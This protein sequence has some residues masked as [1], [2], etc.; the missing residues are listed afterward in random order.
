[1]DFEG[2]HMKSFYFFPLESASYTN[3]GFMDADARRTKK[4]WLVICFC[5]TKKP[6][7]ITNTWWTQKKPSVQ[8]RVSE[9]DCNQLLTSVI[10]LLKMVS[11][12]DYFTFKGVIWAEG[13]VSFRLKYF[14]ASCDTST[15][16]MNITSKGRNH[17]VLKTLPLAFMWS[18][19]DCHMTAA[20]FYRCCPF[21]SLR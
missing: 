9:P 12:S 2:R 15:A 20:P 16:A 17:S 3:Y 21:W 5:W 4:P 14:N 10:Q 8:W 13:D 7:I 6:G 1:M 19:N 18:A 11:L